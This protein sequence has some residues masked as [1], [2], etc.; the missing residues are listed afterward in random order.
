MVD[1][2]FDK[3]SFNRSTNAD[4]KNRIMNYYAD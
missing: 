4:H 3:L 1:R 2:I